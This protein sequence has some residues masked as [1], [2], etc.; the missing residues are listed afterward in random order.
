LRNKKIYLESDLIGLAQDSVDPLLVCDDPFISSVVLSESMNA[1]GINRFLCILD[2]D[3]R[4][5]LECI[6]QLARMNYA[7]Y[8]TAEVYDHIKSK[9]LSVADKD[10]QLELDNAFM[11]TLTSKFTDEG[12]NLWKHNNAVTKELLRLK[13]ITPYT[14]DG[15]DQIV[16]KANTYNYSKEYPDEFKARLEEISKRFRAKLVN[17]GKEL[18]LETYLADTEE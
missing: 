10:I 6:K 3:I 4:I 2:L 7:N 9:I 17:N 16:I 12:S 13:S 5:H 15:F 14:N 1:I 11:D 8:L 18:I